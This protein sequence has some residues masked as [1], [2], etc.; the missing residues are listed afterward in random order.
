MLQLNQIF[1]ANQQSVRLLWHDGD[2]AYWIDIHDS[3]AW[4]TQVLVSEIEMM[5]I[6]NDLEPSGDPFREVRSRLYDESTTNWQ[7]CQRAWKIIEPHI[8]NPEL[9]HRMERGKLVTRLC[10]EH[11]MTK[12]SINRY[13]RRYWQ[14]GM[15]MQALLPDY[16]NSGGA[17]KRR[18]TTRGKL[19]VD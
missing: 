1:K 6:N 13:L 18:D 14:R 15:C 9:F 4:P 3:K 10:T 5:L 11:K 19:G 8:D 17:G 7:K 16:K 12:Q 2:L